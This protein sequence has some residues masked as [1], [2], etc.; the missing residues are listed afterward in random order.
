MCW[1]FGTF[2]ASFRDH[3]AGSSTLPRAGR[4]RAPNR[5]AVEQRNA[6]GVEPRRYFDLPFSEVVPPR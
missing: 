6:F 1:N 4:G 3:A 5:D 2:A